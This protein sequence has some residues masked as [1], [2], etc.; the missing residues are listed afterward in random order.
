T[1]AMELT[2]DQRSPCWPRARRRAVALS[3]ASDVDE[4]SGEVAKIV[5]SLSDARQD[6]RVKRVHRVKHAQGVV[7]EV[8]LLGPAVICVS[9]HHP[10]KRADDS[11]VERLPQCPDDGPPWRLCGSTTC[12]SSPTRRSRSASDSG[13]GRFRRSSP[14]V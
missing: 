4:V 12:T 2:P 1:S 11:W 8:C 7:K 10:R 13:G 5:L 3:E 9:L 6:A 14:S